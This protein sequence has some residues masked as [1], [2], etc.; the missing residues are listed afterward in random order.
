MRAIFFIFPLLFLGLKI[1][2]KMAS[3]PSPLTE[4]R[5]KFAVVLIPSVSDSG[6]LYYGFLIYF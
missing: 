4:G 5:F 1:S 2:K 3:Q 6:A